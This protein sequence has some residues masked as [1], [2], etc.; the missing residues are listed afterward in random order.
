MMRNDEKQCHLQNDKVEHVLL[1]HFLNDENHTHEWK[2]LLLYL[3]I[4]ERKN[5]N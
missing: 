4:L 2:H 5:M 1:C 3:C